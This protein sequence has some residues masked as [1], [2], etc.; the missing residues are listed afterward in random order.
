ME[1]I[2][3]ATSKFFSQNPEEKASAFS[4]FSLMEHFSVGK[5][6]RT[7]F[8]HYLLWK[9]PE[10]FDNLELFNQ[11]DSDGDGLLSF[12]DFLVY[13]YL[14]KTR[15]TCAE[16]KVLV[17]FVF[18]TCFQCFTDAKR[19]SYDLCA[20]CYLQK[21][22]AAADHQQQQPHRP[23]GHNYDGGCGGNWWRRQWIN[24]QYDSRFHLKYVK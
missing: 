6:S 7:V 9:M 23:A 15:P 20:K 10:P 8:D 11:L 3:L 5:V 1:D 24:Q 21:K 18:Y 2:R 19:C 4:E 22:N 16:C 17:K 12:D 13:S 14:S